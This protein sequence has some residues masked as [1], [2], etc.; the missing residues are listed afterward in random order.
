MSRL[1]RAEA[2]QAQAAQHLGTIRLAHNPR[3][4]LVAA[5][6]LACAALL[7]AFVSWAEVARKA[8]LPGVLVPALGTIELSSPQ[9]GQV[10]QVH[11]HEGDVVERGQLLLRIGTDRST[12]DGDTVALVL[13]R[14]A[15][16]RAAL[17]DERESVVVQQRQ[18]GAALVARLRSTQAERRQA[19]DEHDALRA[20]LQLAQ[21]TV[22]RYDELARAGYVST[23]VAQQRQEELLDLRLRERGA[24][25]G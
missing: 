4:V 24:G 2:L 25:R 9:A 20:R 13:R 1:F 22:A 7:I 3:F 5:L 14:L 11:V 8:R 12:A 6:S 16:R 19:A 10:L 23:L 21:A 18:R 15:Q 17:L